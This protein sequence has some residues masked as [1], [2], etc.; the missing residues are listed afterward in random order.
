MIRPI[1]IARRLAHLLTPVLGLLL[2]AVLFVGGTHHHDDGRQ[3]VCAVCSVGHSP[4]VAQQITA[5]AR[6]AAGPARLL[7][8]SVTDAPRQ[9]RSQTALSRAP[10]LA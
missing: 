3:H 10:P 9:A 1:A 2:L 4:A 5:H 8:A 7:H 6:A